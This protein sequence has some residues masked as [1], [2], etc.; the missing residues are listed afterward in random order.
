MIQNKSETL[1]K[2][3]TEQKLFMKKLL[4]LSAR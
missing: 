4:E 1:K 2:A 3:N